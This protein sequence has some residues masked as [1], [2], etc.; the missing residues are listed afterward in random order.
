MNNWRV[1]SEKIKVI[2]EVRSEK[3]EVISVKNK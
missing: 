1:K 2:S 3:L